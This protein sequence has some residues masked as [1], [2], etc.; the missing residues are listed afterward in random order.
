VIETYRLKARVRLMA[1]NRLV[2]ELEPVD[3]HRP[4]LAGHLPPHKW[5]AWQDFGTGWSGDIGCHIFDPVWKG[6]GLQPPLTVSA[7]VQESWKNSSTRRADT[8]PQGDHT[9]WTFPGNEKIGGGELVLEW[10]DGDSTSG[11]HP[12]LFRRPEGIPAESS[13]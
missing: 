10:F 4:L 3:W 8:W 9:V 2:V 11:A 12:Q 6:L 5:R 7:E 13:C 1:R